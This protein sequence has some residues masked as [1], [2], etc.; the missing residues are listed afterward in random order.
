ML[1]VLSL[2]CGLQWKEPKARKCPTKGKIAVK[3]FQ[4]RQRVTNCQAIAQATAE[5]WLCAV[6]WEERGERERKGCKEQ[7][8]K[9][10][11]MFH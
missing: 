6:Q 5:P 4:G 8:P 9:M 2:S 3:N 10:V 11:T 7:C 1:G